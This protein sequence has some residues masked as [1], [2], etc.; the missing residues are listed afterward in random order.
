MRRF[1]PILLAASCASAWAQAPAPVPTPIGQVTEVRGLVTM[2]FG[3]QVATVQPDTPVFDGAR[4]VA[5]SS[6]G[7]ELKFSDGCVVKLQPNQWLSVDG[8]R[9]CPQQ[10]AAVRSLTEGVF[11]DSSFA[12]TTLPLLGAAVAAGAVARLPDGK[13]TPTP[14]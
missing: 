4:F 3:S 12:R 11:A 1:T 9:S 2:S 13:I 6:G 5:S 10:I 8:S 14:R 7:A